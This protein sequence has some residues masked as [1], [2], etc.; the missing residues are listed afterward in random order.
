M[1]KLTDAQNLIAEARRLTDRARPGQY[2]V[3][4][5][6]EDSEYMPFWVINDQTSGEGEWFAEVRVG[7]YDTANL[8]ARSRTL[9]PE[10]ADALESVTAEYDAWQSGKIGVSE[11]LALREENKRLK[12]EIAELREREGRD[13]CEYC[14]D[15]ENLAYGHDSMQ[16][17]GMIYI[18]RNLLTADLFSESMAVPIFYCPV[19]GGALEAKREKEKDERKERPIPATE[20]KGE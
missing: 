4:N 7:D 1:Q 10:L 9:V 8:F 12:A 18:D 17:T 20:T 3:I 15:G 2:S 13:G 19:C 6:N 16:R 5:D 14:R 11:H